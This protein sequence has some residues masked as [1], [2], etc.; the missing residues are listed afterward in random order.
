MLALG[1]PINCIAAKM[2]FHVPSLIPT[3]KYSHDFL[4]LGNSPKSLTMAKGQCILITACLCRL[5][6]YYLFPGLVLSQ[7]HSLPSPSW[8]LCTYCFLFLFLSLEGPS[9][10]SFLLG[11]YLFIEN[12][13]NL[14]PEGRL[15]WIPSIER[16]I[17]LCVTWCSR[18]MFILFKPLNLSIIINLPVWLFILFILVSCTIFCP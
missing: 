16:M 6:A 14:F 15:L 9:A 4:F 5:L 17:L 8:F 18:M 12:Y 11:Y 7:E 10:S 1:W 3:L 13:L 2:I